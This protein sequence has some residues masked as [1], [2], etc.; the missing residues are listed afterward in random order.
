MQMYATAAGLPGPLF[1][2]IGEAESSGRTDVVNS[3]GAVGIWQIYGHPQWSQA[4][5]M[6]PMNNATAAKTL[7]DQDRAAG[8]DGLRPWDASRSVWSNDPAAKGGGSAT[9][10]IDWNDPFGLAPPGL[11]PKSPLQQFGGPSVGDLGAGFDALGTIAGRAGA[12]SSWLANPH[13]W[14]RVAY[15][16]VGGLVLLVGIGGVL[17]PVVAPIAKTAAKVT[18]VGRGATAVKGAAKAAGKNAK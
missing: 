10:A 5:L 4:W 6:N 16:A 14:L 8:G 12:A 2:A 7:Y 3:I 1:A 17:R 15:V 11:A 9:P 18:P 13:N